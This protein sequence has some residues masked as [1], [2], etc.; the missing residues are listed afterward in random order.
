M[1]SGTGVTT[2]VVHPGFVWSS[3]IEPFRQ[4]YGKVLTAIFEIIKP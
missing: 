1:F 4:T 2:Y 3:F